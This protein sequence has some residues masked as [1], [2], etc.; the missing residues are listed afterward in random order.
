[1]PQSL[2]HTP[3]IVRDYGRPLRPPT[4]AHD[5]GT[6]AVF[7]GLYGNLWDGEQFADKPAL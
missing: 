5:Y 7:E 6:V 3:L 1:M 2:A 4:A